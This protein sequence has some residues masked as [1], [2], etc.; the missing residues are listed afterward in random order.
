[1]LGRARFLALYVGA[2][3]VG[4]GASFAFNQT[5]LGVGASG[6][7][8][9]L[10]GA[11]VAYFYRRRR[12]GGSVPLQ[13]L[14]LVLLLNLFIA[15]LNPSIDNLAHVGGFLA[16]LVAMG[17]FDAAGPRNRGVQ[18]AALAVPFLAGVAL[19]VLGVANYPLGSGPTCVGA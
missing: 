10:L 15:R 6:A 1:V 7:I 12:A 18:A 2:G 13:N 9:G 16:G 14:L 11:L 3:L 5:A 4:A 19:A 17:L 8:F